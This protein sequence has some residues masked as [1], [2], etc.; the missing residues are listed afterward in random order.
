MTNEEHIKDGVETVIS[1]AL[2]GLCLDG[3]LGRA[4]AINVSAERNRFR[5]NHRRS[6]KDLLAFHVL[7]KVGSC[8]VV[9]WCH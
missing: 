3:G 2:S 5:L 8:A 9:I 6:A 4:I 7:G 1:G